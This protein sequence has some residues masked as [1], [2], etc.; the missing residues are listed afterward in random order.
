MPLDRVSRQDQDITSIR[1]LAMPESLAAEI[2]HSAT[3]YAKDYGTMRGWRSTER[4]QPAWGQGWAGIRTPATAKHL[5]YQNFGTKP[6]VMWELEGKIIPIRDA[7]G[8]HFIRAVRVG[9][10]GFV[11]MPDGSMIWREQRW[12]HPGIKPTHFLERSI[13]KAIA[14]SR[15][16]IQKRLVFII[17]E[18]LA[19]LR[20]RRKIR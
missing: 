7:T 5:L 18:N 13:K 11:R 2:A 6:R 15:V 16:P 4:L 9:Q 10:P 20:Q 1:M 17:E 19:T 3:Q 14:N 8:I 12:R